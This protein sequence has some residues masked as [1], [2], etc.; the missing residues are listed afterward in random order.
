MDGDWQTYRGWLDAEVGSA[1]HHPGAPISPP[2]P[3]PANCRDAVLV[4][5]REWVLREQMS[6]VRRYGSDERLYTHQ[7]G[8][9]L[10]LSNLMELLSEVEGK[11]CCKAPE[12][13]ELSGAP[14][15]DF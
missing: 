9:L 10:A 3:L 1:D 13:P 5:I 4:L 6:R 14:D 11:I 2:R 8:Y 7:L 12:S 15:R